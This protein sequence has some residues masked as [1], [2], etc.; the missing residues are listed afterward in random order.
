MPQVIFTKTLAASNAELFWFTF[1]SD[2][3][4]VLKGHKGILPF[5]LV[6]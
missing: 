1:Q 3:E 6:K 5:S 4:N 2:D